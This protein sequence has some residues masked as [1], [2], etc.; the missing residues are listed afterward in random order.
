MKFHGQNPPARTRVNCTTATL[1]APYAA[2]FTRGI[3]AANEA[4]LTMR[5]GLLKDG[6]I[7]V[8]SDRLVHYFKLG[9]LSVWL[10]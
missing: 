6:P 8:K 3:I 9:M 1:L 7:H 2:S 5:P 10:T 4:A